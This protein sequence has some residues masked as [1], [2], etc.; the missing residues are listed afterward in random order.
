MY[1]SHCIRTYNVHTMC[2]VAMNVHVHLQGTYNYIQIL[3]ILSFHDPYACMYLS[4][5]I[6]IG[7]GTGGAV[8]ACAPTLFYLA[9]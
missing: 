4:H 9:G 3:Y 5:C 2:N 6:G 1:L 8:G 7:G